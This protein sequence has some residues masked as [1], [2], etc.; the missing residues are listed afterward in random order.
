M[1]APTPLGAAAAGLYDAFA[2]HGRAGEDFSAIIR[3][4]R[5]GADV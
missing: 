2:G 4:L 1:R 5:G 3:F